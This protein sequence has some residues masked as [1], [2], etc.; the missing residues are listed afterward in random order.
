M[1][2]WTAITIVAVCAALASSPAASFAQ[3]QEQTESSRKVA[4]RVMPVYPKM[5]RVMGLKGTVR[6]EALVEPN[7]SV[8]SLEIKGGH[9]VLAEAAA[10][11]VRRWKWV[12]AAHETHEPVIV[13]FDPN[14]Q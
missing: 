8:K 3:Q 11:A 10:D 12:P 7:G 1:W 4:N 13:R 14:E 6:V 9:P 5:A 2:R